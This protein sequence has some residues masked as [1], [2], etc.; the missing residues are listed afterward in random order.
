MRTTGI[1]T[2][3][4]TI[5]AIFIFF[6]IS[7][8]QNFD[9]PIST[10]SDEA[11]NTFK[12]GRAYMENVHQAKAADLFDKAIKLDPNFALAHLYRAGTFVGGF[13]VAKKHIDKAVSL[14]ANVSGGEKN[15]ILYQH[16]VIS[17]DQVRQKMFLDNLVV[18]FPYNKRIQQLAGNY[19]YGISDYETSLKHLRKSIEIDENFAPSYNMIGYAESSL[20]NF[21]SA[22]KAFRKYIELMPEHPNPYDSYA[23][24]LQ[25]RG[26]YDESIVQYQKAYDKDNTFSQ[27]LIG[28][29][30][31]YVF[32]G[33]FDKGREYY[34]MSLNKATSINQRLG[35][36]FWTATSFVHEGR[37]DE[38]MKILAKRKK[39][40]QKEGLKRTVI[41][42]TNLEGFI[43]TEIGQ[44]KKGMEK[45]KLANKMVESSDL[46]TE[47]KSNLALAGRLNMCYSLTANNR[48]SEAEKEAMACEQMVNTRSNPNEIQNLHGTLALLEMKKGNYKTAIDHFEKTDLNNNP[49]NLQKVGVAY[50]KMGNTQMAN[51]YFNRVKTSNQNGMGYALIRQTVSD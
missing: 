20:E 3:L 17:G 12:E 49:F 1:N 27:A 38:A 39:F 7:I 4:S 8:A 45:F 15:L 19:Y 44:T 16:A 37:T 23:E 46:P 29:G 21:D 9:L 36:L 35:S 33:E 34:D 22:E 32:K 26:K 14:I 47:I 30:H 31:N 42:S 13:N 43:L 41:G 18:S 25:K 48:I 51:K 2:I 5:F 11:R 24:L 40:A 10:S 28:L 50:E 6:G